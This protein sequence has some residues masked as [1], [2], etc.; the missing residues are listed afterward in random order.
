MPIFP[1]SSSIQL[2][3]RNIIDERTRDGML[4]I[5]YT[6]IDIYMFIIAEKEYSNVDYMQIAEIVKEF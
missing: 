5:T 2:I 1:S 6:I 4:N 3:I